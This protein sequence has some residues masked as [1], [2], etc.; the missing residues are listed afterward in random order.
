MGPPVR[1]L[2]HYPLAVYSSRTDYICNFFFLGF[3]CEGNEGVVRKR[4]QCLKQHKYD[5]VE[6]HILDGQKEVVHLK[7]RYSI[8]KYVGE[9]LLLQMWTIEN[10]FSNYVI[11]IT[12]PI[13][14]NLT[15][16]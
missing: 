8:K 6:L 9:N 3:I 11:F 16:C 4:A 13:C 15:V 1:G 7:Y 2:V 12:Y 14:Y 10:K 5:R